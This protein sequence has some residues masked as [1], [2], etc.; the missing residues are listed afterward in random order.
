[1]KSLSVF[2]KNAWFAGLTLK[3]FLLMLVFAAASCSSDVDFGEQYKK[4]IYIVNANNLLHSQEYFYGEENK[5]A[6][7]VY[8]ASS[9]PGTRDVTV[10]LQIDPRVLDSLNTL[11]L[12]ENALY[13]DKVILPANRYQISG[14]L[15]VI[16]RAGEQYGILEIPFNSEG[17]DPDI[18]YALPVS[19]VSNDAGYDINPE[20]N[21]VVSEIR[22]NNKYSGDFVGTSTE[23]PT[24][25]RPVQISSKAISINSIRLPIHNLSDEGEGDIDTHFM[26][27]TISADGIVSIAPWRNAEVVDLGGS[28]YDE[29]RQLFEL[30]YRFT[31]DAGKIFTVTEKITNIYAPIIQ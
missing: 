15:E 14:E 2:N 9:E 21:S 31:D 30:H 12:Y 28:F 18:A 3:G 16:I 8:C 26:L 29:V 6:F 19:I 1:M 11:S 13:V 10:R 22:M 7:S 17:L 24:A 27:L 4:T 20:M 23:S 25:I 5:L